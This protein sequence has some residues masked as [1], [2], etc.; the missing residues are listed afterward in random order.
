MAA[1][2]L[3][4]A[5]R[6]ISWTAPYLRYTIPDCQLAPIALGIGLPPTLGNEP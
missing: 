4:L 1:T 6:G 2:R 5:Q 3:G